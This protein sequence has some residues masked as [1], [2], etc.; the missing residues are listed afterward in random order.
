MPLL[1]VSRTLRIKRVV[2]ETFASNQL[3][4][5]L[6][7]HVHVP[8]DD[9]TRDSR[10]TDVDAVKGTNSEDASHLVILVRFILVF[11]LIAPRH[12]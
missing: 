3:S 5:D 7:S 10:T 1:T 9:P 8:S 12:F 4:S 11:D 2:R 6:L